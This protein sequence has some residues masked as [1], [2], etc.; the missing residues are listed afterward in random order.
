M[1]WAATR[2]HRLVNTV[3]T[4]HTQKVELLPMRSQ[5]RVFA[6]LAAIVT[7][8]ILSAPGPASADPGGGRT[9][10][11]MGDSFS[12][13]AP[14]ISGPDDNA[15]I[16]PQTSWP[17]QL[18]ARTGLL[19]T[20]NFIDMSCAGGALNTGKGWTL[21]QQARRAVAAGAFGP[22]TR[23]I[24]LQFGMND[25]WGPHPVYAYPSVDC[26]L[27]LVRGCGFDAADQGRVPDYRAVS[28]DVFADRMRSVVDYVKYYAP[29][30]RVILVG[31]PEIFPA[32][33][34]TA[35]LELLEVGRFVQPRA[36]AFIAYLD[37]LDAAERG[38]AG[39]L[40]IEFFDARALTAGHGSCAAQSWIDGIADPGSL[41]AGAP[42]H[43]SALGNAV[44]AAAIQ[45][46]AGL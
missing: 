42:G 37:S 21:L 27:D 10:V 23:V 39:Q 31:Y 34:S 15:C 2:S 13:T 30:A 1:V 29:K 28:A 40:G 33:Q 43:P 11:T 25:H 44:L 5:I 46:Y 16:R 8:G 19:G 38:A 35:C 4:N 17:T 9:L 18:A 24:T 14:M 26:L 3:E 32:G 12:A 45:Q 41:F 22:E 6:A 20:P 36:E 7:A